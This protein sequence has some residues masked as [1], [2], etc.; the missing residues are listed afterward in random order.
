MLDQAK[1]KDVLPIDTVI[2]KRDIGNGKN[3]YYF[4]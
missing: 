3:D 4:E 2:K 1:E